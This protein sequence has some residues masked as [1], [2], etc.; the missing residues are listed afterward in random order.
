LYNTFH[1]TVNFKFISVRREGL[2]LLRRRPFFLEK[3]VLSYAEATEYSEGQTMKKV[4][5]VP[6]KIVNVVV[7]STLQGMTQCFKL[8]YDS[9]SSV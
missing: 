7:Y 1:P 5:V 9:T 4:I 3:D 6:K 2:P 8:F